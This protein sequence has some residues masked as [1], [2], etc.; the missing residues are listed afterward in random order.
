MSDE[1]SD[2]RCRRIRE[3]LA[4][5][6]TLCAEGDRAVAKLVAEG[7]AAIAEAP[8]GQTI[9]IGQSADAGEWSKLIEELESRLA[10][11][12]TAERAAREVR[13]RGSKGRNYQWRANLLLGVLACAALGLL[14]RAV[15]VWVFCLLVFSLARL[16]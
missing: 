15:V 10:S 8:V 16:L 7:R 14:W 11:V 6:S 1:S 9:M 4:E 5:W 12:A 3:A 13:Q 2:P